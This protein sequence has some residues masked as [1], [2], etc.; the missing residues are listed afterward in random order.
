MIDSV[1]KSLNSSGGTCVNWLVRYPLS[2]RNATDR[3]AYQN[4]AKSDFDDWDMPGW[5]FDELLPTIK[6]VGLTG[7][8]QDSA[9]RC[10]TTRHDAP[11]DMSIHGSGGAM[12][13]SLGG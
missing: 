7:L 10:K 2:G 11:G 6:K 13:V 9:D 5:S 1:D 3:K 4:A 8:C 12:P